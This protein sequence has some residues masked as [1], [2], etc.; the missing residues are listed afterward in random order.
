MDAANRRRTLA[1]AIGLL[2]V[3]AALITVWFVGLADGPTRPTGTSG[4]AP[5]GSGFGPE[6]GGA[7]PGTEAAGAAPVIIPG[8]P[9]ESAR[10]VPGDQV[11][12][13]PTRHNSMDV[14]FVRMM[15]P[16]HAQ[17]LQMADLAPQRAGDP[18]VRALADRIHSSQLP[19]I[20]ALRG[21]LQARRLEPVDAL[22][23]HDHANMPGMQSEA[24]LH[25]LAQARGTEFDRM[26]VE[27]MTAH[28]RGAV[29][30]ATDILRVG[31]DD[32]VREFANSIAVEQ[33][34]EID[35]MRELL[36]DPPTPGRPA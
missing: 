35:R 18:Q 11:D 7:T 8:G 27:M 20:Q 5:G 16:H 26:F 17:A 10:V 28:H 36:R 2:A 19:E 12:P 6:V 25:R 34:V 14:W 33:G 32:T 30:M 3:T 23:G 24:A 29:T 4:A 1:G 21:W 9:G 15:I 13:V 31:I 22:G